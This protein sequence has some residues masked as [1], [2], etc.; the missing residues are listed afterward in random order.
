[1]NN[2]YRMKKLI[3]I[4][5]VLVML[6]PVLALSMMTYSI[7]AEPIITSLNPGTDE[8]VKSILGDAI[9][10]GIIANDITL[11][12]DLETSI[13][14]GSLHG[15]GSW[16]APNNGGGAGVSYI[17]TYDGT[18]LR[19][20]LNAN[21]GQMLIYTTKTAGNKLDLRGEAII[22]DEQ[23]KNEADIRSYVS[24]LVSEIVSKSSAIYDRGLTQGYDFNEA[25]ELIDGENVIDIAQYGNG[26]G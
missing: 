23:S 11:V 17:G 6:S 15:N 1:M 7:Y 14:T 22:L 13:A 10:H 26:A 3:S 8:D 2:N 4:L 19:V 16:S 12:G 5:M 18:D 9:A 21:E 20:R 24:N 25:S